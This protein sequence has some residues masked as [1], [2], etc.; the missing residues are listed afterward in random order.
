MGSPKPRSSLNSFLRIFRKSPSSMVGVA[1]VALFIAMATLGPVL[2]PFD[3]TYYLTKGISR[4]LGSIRWA[5]TS[6]E[7]TCLDK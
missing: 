4:P 6:P 5:L 1:I 3:N 2:L 7:G